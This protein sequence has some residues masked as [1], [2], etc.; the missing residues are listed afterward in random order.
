MLSENDLILDPDQDLGRCDR[1]RPRTRVYFTW[2]PVLVVLKEAI[3]A[4]DHDTGNC[5]ESPPNR[6]AEKVALFHEMI[7]ALTALGNYLGV[8]EN[9]VKGQPGLGQEDLREILEK[10][11]GQHS[12]ACKAAR[13]LRDLLARDA[14]CNGS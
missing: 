8:I 1:R 10:S 5:G 13:R 11:A 4:T 14:P 6:A 9:K 3:V 2:T 7:E 12:R